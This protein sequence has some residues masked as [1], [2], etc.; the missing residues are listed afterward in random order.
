[1]ALDKRQ[2]PEG[3]GTVSLSGER[4]TG[5]LGSSSIS[6]SGQR[7]TG[8]LDGSSLSLS[9]ERPTGGLDGSSVSLSGE[10]PTGGLGSGSIS[11]SG[12]RPTG[13]LGS[14]SIS[15]SG[16]RP[17]G[18]VI[19]GS[20]GAAGSGT[21]TGLTGQRP[22]GGRG[23]MTGQRPT[24]GVDCQAG[25]ADHGRCDGTGF[26]R[27]AREDTA[28]WA[29][30]W[31]AAGVI[32]VLTMLYL[33]RVWRA[34]VVKRRVLALRSSTATDEPKDAPAKLQ[35]PTKKHHIVRATSTAFTNLAHVRVFPLW[36]YSNS[37]ANEWFWTAAYTGIV[38][39]LGMYGSQSKPATPTPLADL[40]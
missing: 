15:L 21:P 3:S 23:P 17:T 12:E 38:L 39:G 37:T 10:R 33:F 32:G 2:R 28:A 22:T 6:L 5:G 4:P 11:L 13:G 16:V 9:G 20:A 8:G 18:G 14:T 30:W 25:D 1:M 40:A 35:V 31:V 36:L 27:Q 34:R 29:T 26:N 24:G 19:D 7:P